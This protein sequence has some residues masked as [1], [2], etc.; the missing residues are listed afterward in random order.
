MAVVSRKREGRHRALEHRTKAFLVGLYS[1]REPQRRSG[2]A[3]GAKRASVGKCAAPER[4][5]HSRHGRKVPHAPRVARLGVTAVVSTAVDRFIATNRSLQRIRKPVGSILLEAMLG[6]RGISA[7]LCASQKSQTL[8]RRHRRVFATYQTQ[9]FSLVECNA[10]PSGSR[11][12]LASAV[13]A[14]G[15]DSMRQASV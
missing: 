11:A 6:G 7:F 2:V 9:D 14:A 5:D 10:A 13:R 8:H 4:P 15:R 12:S 3:V 1:G